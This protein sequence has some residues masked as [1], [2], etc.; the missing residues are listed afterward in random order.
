MKRLQAKAQA[1]T[2]LAECAV[3]DDVLDATCDATAAAATVAASLR[4]MAVA[5]K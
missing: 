2:I 5:C 3:D 4:T 1:Q